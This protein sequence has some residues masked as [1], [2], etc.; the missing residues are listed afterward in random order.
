MG[1]FTFLVFFFSFMI[2]S[3]ALHIGLFV[4][5]IREKL[6]GRRSAAHALSSFVSILAFLAQTGLVLE[7]TN[8]FLFVSSGTFSLMCFAYIFFHF[9]NMGE[10]ARR[11][12]L[13]WE[14]Y[15]HP[16]GLSTDGLLER[17]PSEEAYKR[18]IDRLLQAGQCSHSKERLIWRGGSYTLIQHL[19]KFWGYIV[20][21]PA[22]R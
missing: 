1:D 11:I 2:L 22:K 19:M 8:N 7:F 17:Y 13:L 9:D 4:V 12:R 3:C 6:C 5:I 10:T 15:E 21:G 20:F 16:T 14:L 18:R